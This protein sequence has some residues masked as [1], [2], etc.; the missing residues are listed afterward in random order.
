MSQRTLQRRPARGSAL[1]LVAILLVAMA[2]VSVAVVRLASQGRISASAQSSHQALVECAS[3]AKAQLWAAIAVGGKQYY[4]APSSTMVVTSLHLPDGKE[5]LSPAHLDSGDTSTPAAA[6]G[7]VGAGSPN[8]FFGD[9][10]STNTFRDTT[11][12]ESPEA[13]WV[14]ARCRD[15]AGRTHEV[16]FAFRF[17]L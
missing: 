13:T 5:L 12:G 11:T 2:A 14:T 16:E 6:I 4:Q 8:G 1:V 3:A 7:A 10:D 17:S 15:S 9:T